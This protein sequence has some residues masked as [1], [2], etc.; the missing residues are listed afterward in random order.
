MEEKTTKFPFPAILCTLS[1][2]RRTSSEALKLSHSLGA[3]G[4]LNG[5][6][7]RNWGLA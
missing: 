5:A 2:A 3:L 7:S 4:S 6:N 1:Y